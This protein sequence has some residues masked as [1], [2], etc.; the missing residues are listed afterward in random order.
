MA[1]ALVWFRRDLRM[2]DNPALQQACA[3]TR[4]GVVGLFLLTPGQWRAHADAGSKVD[5]WL[6]NLRDLS[7]NLAT[8]NI[9]LLLVRC[10]TFADCPAAVLKL[11]QKHRCDTVFVN[12]EYEVNERK[13]DR[14]TATLLSA[15]GIGFRESH[16][17]VV[18]PP[19]EIQTGDGRFYSVYT[20]YRR[21]W[22]SLFT[23]YLIVGQ[24]PPPQPALGIPS[25]RIPASLAGFEKF[26]ASVQD[27]PAGEGQA[28][29]R[30]Q[31][32]CR[33][34]ANYGNDRDLPAVAGTSQ[35]SPYLA[36]GVISARQCL[37][38]A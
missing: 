34:I 36:A 21:V 5:F 25:S 31:N 33:L 20:P 22:D 12:R 27:W 35:L 30:L 28:Q 15:H 38:A 24:A 19:A 16:D 11:A 3:H 10:E 23:E 18:V 14:E 8:V 4:E 26:S 13:R 29:Q 32:F 7:Q 37:A 17:R 1:R 9:P 6:R 2:Q